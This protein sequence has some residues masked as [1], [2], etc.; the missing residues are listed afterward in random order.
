MELWMYQNV[1][2]APLGPDHPAA[3]TFVCQPYQITCHFCTKFAFICVCICLCIWTVKLQ[4][5]LYTLC[6]K[7]CPT[8]IVHI[9]AKY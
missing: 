9:F 3:R 5:S 6:L 2:A 4:M 1:F 7:K 8:V